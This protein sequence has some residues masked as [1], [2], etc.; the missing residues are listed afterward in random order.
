MHTEYPCNPENYKRGRELPITYLVYHY[1]GATGGGAANARYFQNTAGTEASAHYFV[2]HA[3]EGAEIWSSVP[4]ADTAWH[5]GAKT[6]RHPTCRN[7]NS[8]GIEMCCK[9]GPK[10][11]YIE[12]E[13]LAA[14]A[15]LGRDIMARY[16]IPLENVVRHYDVT[17]KLCPRPLIDEGAWAAFK[18]RLE[19]DTM[20]QN[21]FDTMLAEALARRAATQATQPASDW[22][23]DAWAKAVAA[24][25]FDGTAPQN[26]LTREQAAQVLERLGLIGKE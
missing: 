10:G 3:S 22:A 16:G 21:T 13:T 20:D 25:I 9:L 14:A 23:K 8:I 18:Q 19:E 12:E 15:A 5:C 6:Y 24:G 17:G 1:V 4:E 7:A 26:P 11:W 2:G